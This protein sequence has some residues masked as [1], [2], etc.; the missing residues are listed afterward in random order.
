MADLSKVGDRVEVW[1]GPT[2]G[3]RV[4][5]VVVHGYSNHAG[6][7]YVRVVRDDGKSVHRIGDLFLAKDVRPVSAVDLLGE[8]AD[9]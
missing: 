3:R 8:V 9:G 1:V 5:G 2:T 7:T 6:V 4:R